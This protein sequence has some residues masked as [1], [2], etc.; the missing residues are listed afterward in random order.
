MT[1]TVL[2]LDLVGY[3]TIADMLEQGLGVETSPRLNRQIQAFVDQGLQSVKLTRDA[4]VMQTTGDGAIL[5]FDKPSLAH[6]FAE[7]VHQATRTH[8]ATKS[9][10]IGKRIFRIGIATGDLVMEPK[11]NG[12]FDIGGMTI[13]R[14]VRLETKARPGEV[15]CDLK[16]FAGL[17]RKQ[18]KG[19][20]APEKVA[21]KRDESFQAHRCVMNPNGGKDAECFTRAKEV[22]K[23]TTVMPKQSHGVPTPPDRREILALLK[24][25]KPNQFDELIFLLNV[26][27]LRRPSDTI[28]PDLRKNELLKWAEETPSDLVN[29]LLE[30]REYVGP[31][32]PPVRGSPLPIPEQRS[33]HVSRPPA[34]VTGSGA[35]PPNPQAT[36]SQN[37]ALEEAPVG[38]Q[39]S[40]EGETALQ[41]LRDQAVDCLKNSPKAVEILAKELASILPE[42]DNHLVGQPQSEKRCYDIIDILTKKIH[43]AQAVDVLV[44]GFLTAAGNLGGPNNE[45]ALVIEK[46]CYLILPTIYR[47][48]DLRKVISCIPVGQGA[49]LSLPIAYPT[50]IEIFMAAADGRKLMLDRP[51]DTVVF[52]AG[53]PLIPNPPEDGVDLGGNLYKEQFQKHLLKKHFVSKQNWPQDPKKVQELIASALQGSLRGRKFRYYF[54]YN[55]DD[56]FNQSRYKII[57]QELKEIFPTIVFIGLEPAADQIGEHEVLFRL[58]QMLCTIAG[59]EQNP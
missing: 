23:P 49:M 12:G 19:Y 44:D 22:V 14:A 25:L 3:S 35:E 56:R 51:H 32:P 11:A 37:R 47:Q 21:G 27:I 31:S 13:A 54:I 4:T 43:M 30:L 9:A 38:V 53:S 59:V 46:V 15:L 42:K 1:K 20:S 34:T 10:D 2:E 40:G 18:K 52:P 36:S 6:A 5:V 50:S 28:V 55:L 7:A 45:C 8:N 48:E 41:K 26:P 39:S 16:T 33:T 57:M 58:N 17:S 29:L 24:Q